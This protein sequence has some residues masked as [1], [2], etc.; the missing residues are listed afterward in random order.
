MQVKVLTGF[1]L[2]SPEVE[3]VAEQLAQKV[4]ASLQPLAGEAQK[5]EVVAPGFEQ[6]APPQ[7]QVTVLVGFALHKPEVEALAPQF[8]QSVFALV[9]QAAGEEAQKDEVAAPGFEQV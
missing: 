4:R 6:L 3:P 9:V 5:E 2:H 8:A 1:A 7:V